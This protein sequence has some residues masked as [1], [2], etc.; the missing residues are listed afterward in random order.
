MLES[1]R[2]ASTRLRHLPPVQC[3]TSMPTRRSPA[4]TLPS[5][6][7]TTP[8]PWTQRRLGYGLKLLAFC[9]FFF[10]TIAALVTGFLV[11]S[12]LFVETRRTGLAANL[13]AILIT[14]V[15]CVAGIVAV[16]RLW[17]VVWAPGNFTPRYA[18]VAPDMA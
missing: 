3:I 9:G 16:V 7:T 17:P 11:V 1:P 2:V 18:P 10:A 15:I 12:L 5:I 13:T 8:P 4:M 6:V 14:G